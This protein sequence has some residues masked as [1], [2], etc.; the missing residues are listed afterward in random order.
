MYDT[1]RLNG[2][3][4]LLYHAK[5]LVRRSAMNMEIIAEIG[6]NHNGDIV[7]AKELIHSAKEMERMLL[8]FKCMM[9]MHCFKEGTD[10][11]ITIVRQS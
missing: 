11:L 9:L 4:I 8:N 3:T 10:G 2:H 1:I 6:Q 7:L 5:S